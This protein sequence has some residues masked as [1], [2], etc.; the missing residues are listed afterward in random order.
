MTRSIANGDFLEHAHVHGNLY[1]TSFESV[2]GVIAGG[3]HCLLDIDVE[4]V[5]T[6]KGGGSSRTDVGCLSVA[7]L[8]VA[9]PSLEVLEER[10]RGRGTES[11][12]SVRRRLGN[13]LCE[14]EYG[15]QEGHFDH[16]VVNDDIDRATKDFEEF[17]RGLFQIGA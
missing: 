9:P 8:F 2:R 14:L 12:E 6:L 16:V 1:G 3:K 5:K 11:E 4:G 7:Y 13:A 17:V 15:M 10:L